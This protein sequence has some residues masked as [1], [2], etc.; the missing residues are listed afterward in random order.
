MNGW[1]VHGWSLR[2]DR[3]VFDA[4]FGKNA[5]HGH[6]ILQITAVHRG[7]AWVGAGDGRWVPFR[8]AAVPAGA[9]HTMRCTPGTR[10]LSI[11][12]FPGHPWAREITE[13]HGLTA[14]PASWA[15]GGMDDRVDHIVRTLTT[16]FPARGQ[17][18]D[19]LAD[20][21]LTDLL[22][23]AAHRDTTHPQL[24]AALNLLTAT[25]PGKVRL[26]DLSTK[27][28]LSPDRLGKLFATQAGGTF[29]AIVRWGRLIRWA[30]A[31]HSGESLTDAAHAAG[32]TD[33]AHASRVCREMTGATPGVL[34]D[35]AS[36]FVQ[37]RRSPTG[38]H[39]SK[40]PLQPAAG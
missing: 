7:R 18:L 5:P 15:L 31:V 34:L 4:Q 6:P 3:V 28:F 9:A 27:V 17:V 33:L 16:P 29:P 2:P 38:A 22:G 25:L 26:T 8:I 39:R 19:H 11:H 20:Q 40:R 10:V 21:V 14:D 13:C 35:A 12:L 1:K 30:L 36:D 32:F 24:R 23:T 37:R